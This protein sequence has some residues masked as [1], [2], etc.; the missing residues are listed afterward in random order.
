ML[1]VTRRSQSLATRAR[2]MNDEEAI[3]ANCVV[4]NIVRISEASAIYSWYSLG[5]LSAFWQT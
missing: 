5:N 1:R 4:Q 3:V 2:P